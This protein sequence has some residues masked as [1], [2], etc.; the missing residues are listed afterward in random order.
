MIDVKLVFSLTHCLK[1]EAV[2]CLLVCNAV[3]IPLDILPSPL[4]FHSLLLP[5]FPLFFGEFSCWRT[6]SFGTL[7]NRVQIRDAGGGGGGGTWIDFGGFSVSPKDNSTLCTKDSAHKA[8][9]HALM[10]VSDSSAP[11][12][13]GSECDK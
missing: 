11:R 3:N 2:E 12:R 10:Q 9:T 7:G 13:V 1:D 8:I 5:S 6:E 4:S